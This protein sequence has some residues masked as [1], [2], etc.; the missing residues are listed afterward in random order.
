MTFVN[1]QG[2]VN[3]TVNNSLYCM[4]ARTHLEERVEN[5][6]RDTALVDIP[7]FE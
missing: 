2:P 6:F 7:T 5:N 1:R 4:R 3:G